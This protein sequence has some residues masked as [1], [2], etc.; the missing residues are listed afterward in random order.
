MNENTNNRKQQDANNDFYVKTPFDS[1]K[2]IGYTS[3][4]TQDKWYQSYDALKYHTEFGKALID[5][6]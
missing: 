3:I 2:D 6:F 1:S 5:G 4:G